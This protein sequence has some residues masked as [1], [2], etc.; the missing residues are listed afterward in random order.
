MKPHYDKDIANVK[1][2]LHTQPTWGFRIAQGEGGKSD[3]K[4]EPWERKIV[5]IDEKDKTYSGRTEYANGLTDAKNFENKGIKIPDWQDQLITEKIN[6]AIYY[7]KAGFKKGL[8]TRTEEDGQDSIKLTP[9]YSGNTYNKVPSGA[10]SEKKYYPDVQELSINLPSIGNTISDVWDIVYGKNRSYAP[11]EEDEEDIEYSDEQRT[12]DKNSLIGAIEIAKQIRAT[13]VYENNSVQTTDSQQ[14]DIYL[15]KDKDGNIKDIKM[16]QKNQSNGSDILTLISQNAKGIYF[17]EG[18]SFKI[19]EPFGKYEPI[20]Q[21]GGGKYCTI[22]LD[23]DTSIYNFFVNALQNVKTP[24]KDDIKGP[25][26][27]IQLTNQ[28]KADK[29]IQVGTSFEWKNRYTYTQ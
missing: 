6:A 15:I 28:A 8:R 5:T 11:K 12:E 18:T 24:T 29:Y 7:N 23:Q 26:I 17:P 4:I 9:A 2:T 1:Y 3:E 22:E 13:K 21:D 27:Q 14:G 10:P 20:V 16:H 25:T 19:T